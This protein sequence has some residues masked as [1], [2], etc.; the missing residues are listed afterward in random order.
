ALPCATAESLQTLRLDGGAWPQRRHGAAARSA[1]A[2]TG[3]SG[4]GRGPLLSH[5]AGER[6]LLSDFSVRSSTLVGGSRECLSKRLRPAGRNWWARPWR[7]LRWS[8]PRSRP[9]SAFF[10]RITRGW[11]E[12]SF[13]ATWPKRTR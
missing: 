10:K 3:L 8:L 7:A 13:C 11:N 4:L 12:P 6:A 5:A 2:G 1:G 9:C